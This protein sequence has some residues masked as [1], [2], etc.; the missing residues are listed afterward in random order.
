MEIFPD[1]WP[2]L[3]L[4]LP[5]LVC[6]AGLHMIFFG[7]LTAYLEERGAASTDARAAA[8]ASN[9]QTEERLDQLE[10]RLKTARAG[11]SMLRKEARAKTGEEESRIIAA[12][13]GEA[14]K[15]V[16]AAIA[17]I[18]GAAERASA[19]LK[20]HAQALSTDIAGQVLGRQPSA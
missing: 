3:A 10:E 9:V 14:D 20:Q 17:D 15:V 6:V 19:D 16:T 18:A 2:T 13:R 1:L 7:P 5:F 8:A 11:A 4:T 12:A